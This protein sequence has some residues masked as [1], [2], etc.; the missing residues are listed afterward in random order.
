MKVTLI[1]CLLV[2]A[3][4]AA[5]G[6]CRYLLNAWIHSR[7][8]TG[9]DFPWGIFWVNVSGCFL[10]AF[11]YTY[12][13]LRRPDAWSGWKPLVGVGFLG[14]Y[15]TFS[16][17]LWDTWRLGPRVGFINLI[18]SGIAGYAAT[19]LAAVLARKSL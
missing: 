4:S 13:D 5:G 12:L 18:A 15:T 19:T 8:T 17:L 1:D 9:S 14:G 11:L 2:G 3:G 7:T 16:T 6:V 10:L